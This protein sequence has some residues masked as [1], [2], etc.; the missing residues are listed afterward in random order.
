MGEVALA[1]CV[2]GFVNLWI[3]VFVEVCALKQAHYHFVCILF[4]VDFRDARRTLDKYVA[5]VILCAHV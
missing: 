5:Y 2:C 1:V 3:V 4:L